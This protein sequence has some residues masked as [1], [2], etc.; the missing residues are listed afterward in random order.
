MDS[1]LIAGCLSGEVPE[2]QPV[3]LNAHY[4]WGWS[5]LLWGTPRPWPGSL[6]RERSGKVLSQDPRCAEARHSLS[7]A[8]ETQQKGRRRIPQ[9]PLGGG[10][11]TMLAAVPESHGAGTSSSSLKER[12]LGLNGPCA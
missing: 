8:W 5:C 11:A 1:E 9:M 12:H 4:C 3:F 2:M 6:N 7:A 10:L